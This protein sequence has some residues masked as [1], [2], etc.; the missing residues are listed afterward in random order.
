MTCGRNS[1]LARPAL[2]CDTTV[3]LYLGRI[4]QVSLLPALF[5]PVY[6]PQPV[7]LEL[8]MGRLTRGDTIDPRSL[9]WPEIVTVSQESVD[10][11]PPNR[12]GT[13]ER[14][15]IAYA[16]TSGAVLAG[17]DDWQAR[18]LAKAMDLP[19]IGTLGVLL[20]AKRFSLV[21]A[22]RPL[23]DAVVIEGFRLGPVLYQDVLE[24]A[25]EDT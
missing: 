4:G 10:Q 24:I 12:L 17:L 2:V 6:V 22:V 9:D 23:V 1:A 21:P 15:V 14:A 7:L 16:N 25:Q 8:D 3:L 11:L 19:A 20:R 13:G 5:E 18:Q